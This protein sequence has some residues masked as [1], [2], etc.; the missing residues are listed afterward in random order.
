MIRYYLWCP[1]C[2]CIEWFLTCDLPLT[3]WPSAKA[4]P[5]LADLSPGKNRAW[6]HWSLMVLLSLTSEDLLMNLDLSHLL[7]WKLGT[8]T[9][10]VPPFLHLL[11]KWAETLC[12]PPPLTSKWF[13]ESKM[14]GAQVGSDLLHSFN[15][16]EVIHLANTLWAPGLEQ[17][18]APRHTI[19]PLCPVPWRCWQ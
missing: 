11:C 5:F 10:S 4:S 12:A 13:W 18:L 7:M 16:H 15:K 17:E 14:A 3:V 1:Y 8:V 9:P 2:M 19:D 6:T